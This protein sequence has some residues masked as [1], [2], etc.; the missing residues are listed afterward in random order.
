MVS[1]HKELNWFGWTF[2]LTTE[3]FGWPIQ[4]TNMCY[5]LGS[6]SIPFSLFSL[7]WGLYQ[8][9]KD[10][11]H[12]ALQSIHYT[13]SYPIVQAQRVTVRSKCHVKN[14]AQFLVQRKSSIFPIIN[15]IVID[16]NNIITVIINVVWGWSYH[17]PPQKS[18]MA[19]HCTEESPYS[20]W[21]SRHDI[22]I[23]VQV[24]FVR[25]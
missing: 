9:S 10:S 8:V 20:A 5:V 24:S 21:P 18:S 7:N 12:S 22:I 4:L 23:P 11:S 6:L 2:Y 19:P 15:T 25:L 13:G 1:W 14:L 17:S 3:V 16:V